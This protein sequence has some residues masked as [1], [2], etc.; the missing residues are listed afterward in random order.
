MTTSAVLKMQGGSAYGAAEI[1]EFIQKSTYRAFAITV[2]LLFLLFLLFWMMSKLSGVA[3]FSK[4]EGGVEIDL[5][6]V[7]TS[8]PAGEM[9]KPPPLPDKDILKQLATK[10][11]SG[12]FVAVNEK[13]IKDN[14]K[15]ISNF[16]E[17]DIS[18]ARKT[19]TIADISAIN[20]INL[21][22]K[23]PV[24][25]SSESEPD[26]DKFEVYEKDP[27][28]DLVDVQRRV[29]YP[30]MAIRAGVEGI[31]VIRVLI[32]KDGKPLKY[33]IEASGSIMLNQAAVN[34]VMSSVY[35][36]GIQNHVPVLCWVS[37]PI[38]FSL[39]K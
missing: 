4:L 11:M 5:T 12:A 2:S 6:K 13:D 28:V 1:K 20:D 17:N 34:A 18:L 16:D 27:V 15:E 39:N 10:K 30:E 29:V 25:I 31:V 21:T 19:G 7:K 33:S 14:L 38:K 23:P 32:G 36:P 8:E 3:A 35:K 37:I 24:E 26:K 22:E 9:I